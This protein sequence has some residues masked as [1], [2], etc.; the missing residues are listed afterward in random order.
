MIIVDW[1]KPKVLR[2]FKL[3]LQF[4]V[5][6]CFPTGSLVKIYLPGWKTRLGQLAPSSLAPSF[7]GIHT[8]VSIYSCSRVQLSLAIVKLWLTYSRLT[9]IPGIVSGSLPSPHFWCFTCEFQKPSAPKNRS[10]ARPGFQCI[11]IPWYPAARV[12]WINI[13]VVPRFNPMV[14]QR[15]WKRCQT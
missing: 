5:F 8:P 9:G 13:L 12:K 14:I 4:E 7:R 10:L 6:P 15:D 3:L 2:S 11:I 1:H